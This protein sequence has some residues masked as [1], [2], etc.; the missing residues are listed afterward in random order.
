ML[1]NIQV[2]L[3]IKNLKLQ[4]YREL[5]IVVTKVTTANEVAS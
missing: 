2:I 1:K 4:F 5:K 3:V